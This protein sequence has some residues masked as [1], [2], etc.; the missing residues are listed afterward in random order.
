VIKGAVQPASDVDW[1]ALTLPGTADLSLETFDGSAANTCLNI[2]TVITLYRADGTTVVA[3][4]DD[5]GGDRCSKLDSRGNPSLARLPAGTYYV[6]VSAYAGYRG[7]PAYRL[8][9]KLDALCGNGAREGSEQCDGTAG[10]TATCTRTPACSDG[11]LDGAEKCDDGNT[12]AGDGC[13]ATCAWELQAETE[14][15]GTAV[16]AS[17]PLTA[18]ALIGA[19][20]TPAGD[21]DW[22]R[23]QLAATSDLKLETFDGAGPG[24]C[25]GID[26]VVTLYASNGT[27]VLVSR[28]QGGPG[29]CGAIDPSRAN[30]AA[31]RHLAAGTYFVKVEDYLNDGAILAYRLLVT[32]AAVCGNGVV[33]GAEECDGSAGCTA[34][35]DRAAVCGDGFVDSPEGCDDGNV[36]SGDGCSA[37]CAPEITLEAEPNDTPPAASGPLLPFAL[38]KGAISP[39]TDVDFWK[40]TLT[41]QSDLLIET[42][43]ASGAGTCVG[44]D[45]V[46][47]LYG[48]NGVT[49][50]A[51]RDTGSV[52]LCARLDPKVDVGVRQLVP[53]TY[54]VKVEDAG[55]NTPIA[56]YTMRLRKASRCGNGLLEGY[57][58]CDGIAGCGATCRFTPVCGDGFVDLG[59]T[60]DDSNTA[61]GDC[62]S[63]GCAIETAEAE[64]NDTTANA[65][66][67]AVQ[68]TDKGWVAG[69]IGAVGDLDLFRLTVT[70]D[71]VVQ[72]ET[73]DA[74]ASGCG[75]A[76]TLRILDSAGAELWRDDNA[77]I[78]SC[79][80]LVVRLAAGTYYLRVEQRGST[81]TISGYLLAARPLIDRGLETEPNALATMATVVTGRE[82]VVAG[83]HQLNVDSDY[84]AITVPAGR[85]I[86][87]ELIEGGAETCESGGVDS[88]LTLYNS[89]GLALGWDDDAG[90]GACSRIDG[91]GGLPDSAFA[92]KLPA[93]I[94]YLQVEASPFSQGATSLAGQFDYRVAISVR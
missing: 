57:E 53:G 31:A 14:P 32:R 74:T 17:G 72:V 64:P 48:A 60:C 43:D 23:V 87:A 65:N 12:A 11:F 30:D 24:S 91:T 82:S 81:G 37:A 61:N 63:A 93:G 49:V 10:C 13:S 84:F 20:I 88:Y 59:E 73:F 19:A 28:D 8:V 55:N 80:S 5:S 34:T 52:G 83:T 26:T 6:T 1:F 21:A 50:L 22:F 36:V 33:E 9:V 41:E 15:N 62:C 3:S 67:S 71:E 2:D 44:I 92:S 75:I 85:S 90:R 16:T 86:R 79:S 78:F 7:F 38:V 56:G 46:I 4:D 18:D 29:N 47:T 25:A 69:A 68:L 70:A 40:I 76:T 54:Y 89:A 51:T 27:T 94:Y 39:G 42:F 58:Q 77:G 35:C 66:A 45:T